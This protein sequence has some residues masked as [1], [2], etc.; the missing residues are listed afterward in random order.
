MLPA[1]S[2]HRTP[3]G[4]HLRRK[5]TPVCFFCGRDGRTKVYA[6]DLD[7]QDEYFRPA[8]HHYVA[9]R[10][11]GY[12]EIRNI[13]AAVLKRH[14]NKEK[15]RWNR[16]PDIGRISVETRFSCRRRSHSE[17]RG[18]SNGNERTTLALPFGGLLLQLTILVRHADGDWEKLNKRATLKARKVRNRRP[19]ST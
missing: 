12:D 13:R 10:S 9:D 2:I 11:Q 17:G 5:Q 14:N 7:I 3:P 18:V 15:S 6:V 19:G 16:N 4:E 1:L 8:I